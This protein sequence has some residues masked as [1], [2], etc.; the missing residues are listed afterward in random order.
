M[1]RV[2]ICAAILAVMLSAGIGLYIR[3]ETVADRLDA[4]LAALERGMISD[5][6]KEAC[7]VSSEWEEFC[8]VNV[9]LTNLE[10]A[11]EVSGSLVRLI[12]K[13]GYD[14][15]DIAEECLAAR[16]QL[17]HFRAG[18]AFRIENIF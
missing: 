16:Y 15:D 1:K 18:R 10:G 5:P 13:A 3:T 17:E 2:I 7:S 8:A 11:A 9:F 14:A 12:A 4:R 6:F